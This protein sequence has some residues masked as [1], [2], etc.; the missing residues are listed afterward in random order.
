VFVS[1]VFVLL[2][3]EVVCVGG[4]DFCGMGA[5]TVEVGGFLDKSK[6]KENN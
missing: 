6:Q 1:C 5:I 2:S 4:D 3:T